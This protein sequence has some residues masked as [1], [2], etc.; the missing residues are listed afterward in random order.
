MKKHFLWIF[1]LLFLGS[2]KPTQSYVADIDTSYKRIG[3]WEREDAEMNKLIAPYKAQLSDVM[4]ETL[5]TSD[6][7]MEKGRPNSTLGSWFVDVM[8]ASARKI[9][10]GDIAFATQNY[11]G[12]RVTG[13]NKGP[14]TVSEIYEIMPFDNTLVVI[15]M[16]ANDIKKLLN[17]IANKGGWPVSDNLRFSIVKGKAKDILIGGEPLDNNKIYRVAIPDYIANGGDKAFFLKKLKREDNGELL[18]DI[19]IQ[20]LRD[21]PAD[22]KL[23]KNTFKDRISR[24]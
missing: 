8:E 4:N 20:Y 1:I 16:N 15:E 17:L 6:F 22:Q 9:Y 5:A 12:I 11:G 7:A 2:C 3:K 14:I 19:L 10:G 21:L 23:I 18:R 13:L 24:K